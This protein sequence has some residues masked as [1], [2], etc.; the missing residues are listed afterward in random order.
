MNIFNK[1]KHS[2][3]SRNSRYTKDNFILGKDETL[4]PKFTKIFGLNYSVN[5]YYIKIEIQVYMRLTLMTNSMDFA[6]IKKL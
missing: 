1:V 6:I 2:N 5:I 3:I 4:M